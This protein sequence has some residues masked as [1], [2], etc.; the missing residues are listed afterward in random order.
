[1][2]AFR[3]S[4]RVPTLPADREYC[5]WPTTV[6]VGNV[7]LKRN[8]SVW[9]GPVLRADNDPIIVGENT[10][11]QDNAVP[12]TDVGQPVTIGANV[13]IGY[14]VMLH[15]C[16]IGD[17]TL[18]GIGSVVLKGAKIGANGI[19]EAS[20]L[21]TEG[22]E[23]PDNSLVMGRQRPG[24]CRQREA[25]QVGSRAPLRSVEGNPGARSAKN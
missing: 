14:R 21:I 24:L 17:G 16:S 25:V 8:A 18:V 1:M 10:N 20:S 6:V 15:G 19:I 12:H 4:D 13:T 23:T 3:L 7:I 22:K 11:I 2:N 9:F 5:I